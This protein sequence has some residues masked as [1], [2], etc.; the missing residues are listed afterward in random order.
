MLEMEITALLLAKQYWNAD[1]ILEWKKNCDKNAPEA[2]LDHW[3]SSLSFLW[4]AMLQFHFFSHEPQHFL[5]FISTSDL[6]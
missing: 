5:P 1:I 6:N 2:L 4:K 3:D